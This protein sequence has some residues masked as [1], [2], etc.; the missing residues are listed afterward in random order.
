MR[1]ATS[2]QV[3]TLSTKLPVILEIKVEAYILSPAALAHRTIQS[4]PLPFNP[5]KR[6]TAIGVPIKGAITAISSPAL[7]ETGIFVK[8]NLRAMVP[9]MMAIARLTRP[10]KIAVGP[11]VTPRT[12]LV[13]TPAND[14]H[15]GPKRA[16]TITV[17]TVSRN[18]R[19]IFNKETAVPRT[20]FRAIPNAEYVKMVVRFTI[21]FHFLSLLF[22]INLPSCV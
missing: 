8:S 6:A 20:T 4:I 1:N 10:K 7:S 3:I 13:S 11:V 14:P 9:T 19:G 5:P 16:A 2:R 22:F 21:M 18:S 12:K 15:H 17:P